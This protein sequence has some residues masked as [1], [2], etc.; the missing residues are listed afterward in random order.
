[1][2]TKKYWRKEIANLL[3]QFYESIFPLTTVLLC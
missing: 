2:L 1:M 3:Q